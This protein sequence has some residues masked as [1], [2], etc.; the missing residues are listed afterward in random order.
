VRTVST[1]VWAPFEEFEL[2]FEEVL[3]ARVGV[4]RA[5]AA[6]NENL[7]RLFTVPLLLFLTYKHAMPGLNR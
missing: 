6:R 4:A 2:E 3:P 1:R 7:N 5:T